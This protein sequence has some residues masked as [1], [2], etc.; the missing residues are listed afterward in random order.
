ME[1]YQQKKKN[2]ETSVNKFDTEIFG[3]FS[4]TGFCFV[5]LYDRY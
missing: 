3:H 2:L 4:L 1:L 5:L